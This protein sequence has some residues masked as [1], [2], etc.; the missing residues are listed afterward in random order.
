MSVGLGR[1]NNIERIPR[2]LDYLSISQQYGV[3]LYNYAGRGETS[4]RECE[5]SQSK[6]MVLDL[7]H[8]VMAA[9]KD[10]WLFEQI[11]LLGISTGMSL[12]D[13][14]NFFTNVSTC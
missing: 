10:G 6:Q 3:L 2:W 13:S 8:L 4:K 11:F 5:V 1:T 9:N 12:T 14:L 7:K